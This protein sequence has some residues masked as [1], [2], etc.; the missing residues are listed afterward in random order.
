[1][2][3]RVRWIGIGIG[4]ALGLAAVSL[5]TLAVLSAA[6]MNR[7]YAVAVDAPPVPSDAAAVAA[8]ERLVAARGCADCHGDDLGGRVVFDDAAYGRLWATNLTSGRGGVGP[9]YDD[10]AFARAVWY[11]VG[12]DGRPLAMMPSAEYHRALDPVELGQ[13]LAYLR[14]APPVDRETPARRFGPMTWLGHVFGMMPL[15]AVEAIDTSAPPPAPIEAAATAA[16]GAQLAVFCSGCHGPDLAGQATP[17]NEPAPN[18]TPHETGLAGW[19]RDDLTRAL[20]EGVRP[21]GTTMSDAMPWR[22]LGRMTDTEIAALW[23]YLSDLEPR[24]S[25]IG[26]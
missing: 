23:A 26:D 4:G 15:A 19:T 5:A 20:R 17:L 7:A 14:G 21:D 10:E 12:L 8:G 13:I 6:R 18:L 2:G 25:A 24:A 9:D 16:Y 22:N 11:G 3:R 1:M